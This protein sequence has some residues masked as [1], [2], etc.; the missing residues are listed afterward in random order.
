MPIWHTYHIHTLLIG[1]LGT[2][3]RVPTYL[4]TML[5]HLATPRA[6]LLHILGAES[7]TLA[8][9]HQQHI[10]PSPVHLDVLLKHFLDI[11]EVTQHAANTTNAVLHL[12]RQGH[13]TQTIHCSFS[14]GLPYASLQIGFPS[15]H[16]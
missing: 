15:K 13:H 16:C 10:M 9:Y 7:I 11:Q 1:S 5:Y 3:L 2:C 6:P 14:T 8:L 12:F 4:T